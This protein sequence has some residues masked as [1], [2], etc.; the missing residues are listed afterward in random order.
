MAKRKQTCTQKPQKSVPAPAARQGLSS[1]WFPGIC[2]ALLGFCL[3]ANTL[4][5][6][7]CLDDQ[8]TIMNNYVV[9][10]GIKNI[11]TLFATEYRYGGMS[12]H[13]PGPLYRPLPLVI[14]AAAWQLAPD[15][16]GFYHFINVL[17]FSLTGWLLWITWRRILKKY[18]PL[19]PALAVLL[20]MAHPVHT[21]V[22]ANIK[23]LDEIL[24][25]LLGTAALYGLSR[26]T[27][28]QNSVW[29]AAALA[30]YTLALF[31]KESTIVFVGLFPLILWFFSEKKPLE[32]LKTSA[33]FLLPAGLFLAVRATVLAGQ[34]GQMDVNGMINFI[35]MAPDTLTGLASALA[36]G[37]RYLA[38]LV[39]PHPLV[40]DMS[41]PQVQ[42]VSFSDWRALAGLGAYA[43]MLIWALWQA[44]RR[45][46]PAFAVLFFLI[47]FSLLSNIFIV[48]YSNYA[49][50]VL[51]VPSLG[52]AF[53]LAWLLTIIFPSTLSGGK[54]PALLWTV[55]ALVLV[56][57]GAKT[58]S[59]NTAWK[60]NM[61]LFEADIRVSPNSALLQHNYGVECMLKGSD[62]QTG[63]VLDIALVEKSISL[64]TKALGA[65]PT[66][67]ET[68][69]YRGSAYA[70]LKKDDLAIADYEKAIEISPN[71]AAGLSA[72]GF[73][74]LNVR[75]E[76]AQAEELY[77]RAIAA[78]PRF[79]AALRGL[80]IALAVQGKH[81]DAI[82][83]WKE[84]LKYAPDDVHLNQSIATAYWNMGQPDLG[85]QFSEKAA[86]LKKLSENNLPH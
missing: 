77:R 61:A 80:G 85:K 23:S 39:L 49:E 59:R 76:P 33:W 16:P 31:S 4:G 86:Q 9:K 19:L 74:Q 78:D 3:Y 20:F 48:S 47:S 25:L 6:Q 62:K 51:Y 50:R 41:Y 37:W 14:F 46:F 55:V 27:D 29:L 68:L 8:G 35:S 2:A 11:P 64:F 65:F 10:G 58:V 44:R 32:I 67:F 5:N 73:L 53:A 79:V 60:N 12:R 71:Y 42:L 34:S 66:N 40:S 28:E 72:L 15:N 57:Y 52:F 69:G 24:G 30:A 7:Y 1:L 63:V 70:R 82:T 22:V 36:M 21:E 56:L 17:F 18:P 13:N 45:F 43:A 83:Q 38:V 81:A 84:A 26:Y 54:P 75:R